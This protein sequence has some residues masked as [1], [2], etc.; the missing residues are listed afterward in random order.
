MELGNQELWDLLCCIE[1]LISSHE[2]QEEG[3][4][5]EDEIARFVTL[6]DKLLARWTEINEP[7][8]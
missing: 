4:L 3:F 1:T 5:D 7:R 8:Q 2:E 6:H